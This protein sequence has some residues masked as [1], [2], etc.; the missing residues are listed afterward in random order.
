MRDPLALK[1]QLAAE[2]P[3]YEFYAALRLLE[4]AFEDKPRIGESARTSG[5][6]VRFTQVASLAFAPT[7][8]TALEPAAGGAAERL[9]LSF[10]GLLGPN[11]PMPTHLTEYVRDRSRNSNDEATARFLD[12]F[13]HR[14]I[15]LLYRAWSTAQPTVSFD[16]PQS[17]RFGEYVASLVGMGLPALHDRDDVSDY[18]KLH[19]SGHLARHSRSAEGLCRIL[20]DYFKVPTK[21][22]QFVG[23][24][25]EL[26]VEGRCELRPGRRAKRLG[27]DTVL[28]AR[29]YNA[30]SK[31]RIVLG[32]MNRDQYESFLPG[33]DRLKRLADWVRNYLG[34]SLDWDV[35]L[36]LRRDEIPQLKLG[37]GARLGQTSWVRSLSASQDADDLLLASSS[38]GT[39]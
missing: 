32:P 7:A 17:D 5:D 30:Q 1:Q 14:M 2:A 12:I 10:F 35:R 29:V 15:S 22:E 37:Q 33:Q 26:P 39:I 3:A 23:Q 4:C 25:L 38:N 36:I 28:G 16:R 27:M 18:A 20:A 21:I 24:W 6:A 19:F 13:H 9:A 8:L 31:F 34:D 11:G